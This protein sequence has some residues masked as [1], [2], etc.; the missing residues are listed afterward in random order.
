MY[1]KN[2]DG[3]L[4]VKTE[5]ED[6]WKELI[7]TDVPESEDGYHAE[8]IWREEDDKFL[9]V[10]QMVKDYEMDIDDTEAVE[11]LLGGAS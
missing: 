2:I 4:Y 6:G 8:F 3:V 5:Q 11:I 1:G 7:H 9:Q 10:W